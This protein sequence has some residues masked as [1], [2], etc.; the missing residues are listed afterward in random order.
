MFS[1]NNYIYGVATVLLLSTH[2]DAVTAN[3]HT[4]NVHVQMI[5][6]NS[7]SSAQQKAPTSLNVNMNSH[8]DFPELG[9]TEEGLRLKAEKAKQELDAK[10][11]AIQ[12]ER[13]KAQALMMRLKKAEEEARAKAAE[14]EAHRKAAEEEAHRKVAEEEAHRKA[15]EEEA[16]AKA[17]EEAYRKA[18]E[19]EAHAKAEEEARRK[20]AEEEA[21]AKKILNEQRRRRRASLRQEIEAMQG[22]MKTRPDDQ[23]QFQAA[24]DAKKDAIKSINELLSGET[25]RRRLGKKKR[26][27]RKLG[28]MNIK[29]FGGSIILD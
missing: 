12:E 20:A 19:E 7:G 9:V 13:E 22:F 24:I 6:Q 27:R 4:E 14:E 26:H 3:R 25:K 28:N 17:E 21:R 15:A 1:L 16:R 29:S 5:P 2:F 8:T 18:A 23:S 11:K 10:L